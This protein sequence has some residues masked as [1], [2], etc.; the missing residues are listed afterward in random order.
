[1]R[2][3]SAVSDAGLERKGSEFAL[4]GACS[5]FGVELIT[6]ER[7]LPRSALDDLF[8]RALP[9]DGS[10][11]LAR[12]APAHALLVLARLVHEE[13][14]LG[15][16]RRARPERILAEDPHAWERARESASSWRA[17]RALALLERAAAVGTPVPVA[18]RLRA[19]GPRAALRL[20]RRGVLVALS[21][22]DGA[23]KSSQARWLADSLTALGADVD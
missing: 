18:E 15:P 2:I 17:E 1:E 19:R 7:F 14:R 12:P 11:A 4:F 21:G 5:A 3:E 6:A 23:G 13:G 8:G 22:I 10:T 16:K 20:P 9:L